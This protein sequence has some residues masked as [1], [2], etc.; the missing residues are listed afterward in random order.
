MD[1]TDRPLLR[2]VQRQAEAADQAAQVRRALA[3]ATPDQIA[4]HGPVTSPGDRIRMRG[5]P[6]S[7]IGVGGTQLGTNP[8][9]AVLRAERRQVD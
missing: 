8:L 5:V 9:H 7:A 2:W 1:M 3:D 4:K 6:I